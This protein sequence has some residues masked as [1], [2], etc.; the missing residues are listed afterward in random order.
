M[1]I[2]LISKEP[3]L[4]LKVKDINDESAT[5]ITDTVASCNACLL[6]ESFN[7]PLTVPLF[8]Y[9]KKKKWVENKKA[10]RRRFLMLRFG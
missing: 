2:F 10:K 6:E 1:A 4:E 3:L 5:L 7:V 9:K 8:F